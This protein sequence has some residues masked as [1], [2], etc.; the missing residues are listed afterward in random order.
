MGFQIEASHAA[1]EDSEIPLPNNCRAARWANDMR[2]DMYEQQH[3]IPQVVLWESV[4]GGYLLAAASA[5]SSF[6]GISIRFSAYKAAFRPQLHML[7]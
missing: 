1:A 2:T 5:S 4:R 6:C 3:F 7:H